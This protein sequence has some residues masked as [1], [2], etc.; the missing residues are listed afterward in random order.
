MRFRD[1]YERAEGSLLA[2]YASRSAAS[3]GRA[4]DE[5]VDQT[6]SPFTIDR[7]R[8]IHSNAFR[9]L[10]YKT[11]VFV[12]H[13]GDH[14]RNRLT[15]SLEVAAVGRRL[16]RL[17]GLNEELVES[18]ALAHD[19]GHSPFGHSGERV[20]DT[21]MSDWGG[22]EH[23]R[24]S[25]RVV[26]II[27]HRHHGFRGM[28]LTWETREGIA[29]HNTEYDSPE[30][31]GYGPGI[32]PSLEAQVACLADEIAYTSHDLDDGLN[33]GILSLRAL[34]DVPLWKLNFE[35][36]QQAFPEEGF[37]RNCYATIR[38]LISLLIRDVAE[39]TLRNL[40]RM[41]IG[42][43]DDARQAPELAVAFTA[44]V[45]Q[46]FS[47]MKTFLYENLY[48]HH[49]VR[50]MAV[51]AEKILKELFGTYMDDH[52]LLPTNLRVHLDSHA[53]ERVICDYLAGMTDRYAINE[54]RRLFT[55]EE[56]L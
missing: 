49:Q 24:Q 47:A 14:Y 13:E 29:K 25:L 43:A 10:E 37:R 19:L 30:I 7:D 50:R 39:N 11:Q 8:V 34:M 17:L 55:P 2:P 22:F 27:E 32:F 23:N 5:S 9:R 41:S 6:R 36:M 54:Y 3:R 28:N 42:S 15:H 33:S 52:S 4:H 48:R 21:L 40:D 26:E 18:V 12:Y 51:K 53:T 45:A 31:E 46:E 35:T 20:L 44:G 38:K 56:S 1:E 16:A